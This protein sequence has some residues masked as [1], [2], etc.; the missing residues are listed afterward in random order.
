M[1]LI[2]LLLVGRSFFCAASGDAQWQLCWTPLVLVNL[3]WSI[4]VVALSTLARQAQVSGLAYPFSD[5]GGFVVPFVLFV[6]IGVPWWGWIVPRIL[7]FIREA[8]RSYL[9]MRKGTHG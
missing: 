8:A 5:V 6:G 3:P 4:V 7:A 2:Y 9:R 1:L